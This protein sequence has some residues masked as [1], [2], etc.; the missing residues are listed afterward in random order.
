MLGR[1]GGFN[2]SCGIFGMLGMFRLCIWG[3]GHINPADPVAHYRQL[4]AV[5]FVGALMVEGLT[6]SQIGNQLFIFK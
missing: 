4:L 1:V 3:E 5:C 2:V 6:L